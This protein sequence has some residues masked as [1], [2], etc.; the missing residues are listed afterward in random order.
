[1]T[2][3]LSNWVMRD[4]GFKVVR[5]VEMCRGLGDS[6]FFKL[7]FLWENRC[8]V[9]IFKAGDKETVYNYRGVYTQL[10]LPKLLDR[11]APNQ[12]K[13]AWKHLMKSNMISTRIGQQ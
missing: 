6:P 9:P 7:S 4:W 2:E 13:V 12:L 5:F 10:V 1:M 3:G 11:F 8:L